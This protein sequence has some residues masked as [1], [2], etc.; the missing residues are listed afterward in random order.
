MAA[1]E[2]ESLR[3]VFP[4]TVA[5]DG[6]TWSAERGIITT[7]L[8][9]N[10]AGKSTT[11]ECLEGLQRP[12]SGRV[13]VLGV[14]P[15]AA[16]AD[17]RSR[18]GV[19]FQ[20]GGLPNTARP[21]PLLRHLARLYADPW[22]VDP[23]AERLGIPAFAGTP[24]RRMSGGQKQRVALA[25]ALIG[26]P[27]VVFLDEPTAGLDP[28]ARLEVWDLVREV[29]ADGSAVV[30]TTHSFEE[31]ERIGEQVVIMGRGRVVASG[32]TAQV[33]GDGTLEERYF[34][35]TGDLR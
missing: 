32:T 21:M 7:V 24:I 35:L 12:D 20:D 8:G 1:V 16:P 34:A 13:R 5:V 6:A 18:V 14:D 19:M 29:A 3:R 2:V 31:T 10:G 23:L 22:P 27:E 33:R 15:W 25:A 4:G 17:H 30:L 11:I 26:R 28:H 9:P